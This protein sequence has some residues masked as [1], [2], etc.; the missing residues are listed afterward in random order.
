MKYS[1]D[2]EKTIFVT[3]YVDANS[4][5]EAIQKAR[6][7]IEEGNIDTDGMWDVSQ[8]IAWDKS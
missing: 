8:V 6:Y 1:V 7:N 3:V 2:L 4:E 5:E